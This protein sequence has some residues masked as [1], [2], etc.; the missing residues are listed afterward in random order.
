M[1]KAIVGANWGDEGK[2]KM[3]DLFAGGADVVVRFQGGSN[4]GHT[5]INQYGKNSL[6]LLPSGVFYKNVVNILANGVALNI[7]FFLNEVET[8]KKSIAAAGDED[9]INIIVSDKAQV[10]LPYH[11]LLDTL[12]EGRLKERKQGTTKSGIAPLFADKHSRVGIQLWQLFDD[13][14]LLTKIKDNCDRVNTLL[15]NMYGAQPVEPQAIFDELMGVRD[16]IKHY[17]A[18]TAKFLRNA[19]KEGK[20]ILLEGQLGTLRDVEHGIYPYSTSSST[21]AGYAAAGTGIAPYDIKEIIA[22]IKAYSSSVGEG[23]FVVEWFGEQGDELRKRGG[24]AGEYGAS[25]G[26]PRRVGPFDLVAT[27]YGVETQGATSLALTNLDVLGY[28]HEIPVCV[29]YDIEGAIEG[30]RTTD[31]PNT[32]LQYRAKPVFE[33]LPGWN[34]NIRGVQS[35]AHLPDNARRYVAYLEERLSVPIKYISTGPKREETIMR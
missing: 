15:V 13:P 8:V 27:R 28:L 3:T 4:A 23:P 18:D 29:A 33:Y 5:I 35:E 22:V 24:D 11:I 7:P 17:M 14:D 12:E 20:K 2:G 25:T 30:T 6:H 21:L 31:F 9:A 10:L 32:A 26:R 16:S 1:V 34:S 19:V